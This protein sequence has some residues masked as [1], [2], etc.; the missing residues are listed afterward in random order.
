MDTIEYLGFILTP[1]GLHMDLM[2][3][4][5]IQSWLELWNVCDVQ[6]FIGFANFYHHFITDY[7]QLTLPLTNLCKKTTPWIFGKTETTTFQSLKNTFSTAPV[8]CHWAPDLRMMVEMDVSDHT[9]AGILSVTTQ[10]NEICPVA[11][12]S[13]SLQRPQ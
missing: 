10:D 11:F 13:P 6:S 7:S 9:I 2:K 4:A 3:V 12:F 8:L 1:T 5:A